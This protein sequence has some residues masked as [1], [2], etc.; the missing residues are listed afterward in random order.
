MDD[1]DTMKPKRRIGP[2]GEWPNQRRS[3]RSRAALS[4]GLEPTVPILPTAI[5]LIEH[6]EPPMRTRHA[7]TVDACDRRAETRPPRGR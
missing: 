2:T 7:V 3:L 5:E 1:T 4:I 6:L